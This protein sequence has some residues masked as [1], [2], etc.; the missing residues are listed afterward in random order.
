MPP[1]RCIHRALAAEG[2]RPGSGPGRAG[3]RP[4]SDTGQTRDSHSETRVRRLSQRPQRVE[5]LDVGGAARR[6]VAGD[7]RNKPEKQQHQHIRQRVERA[8]VEQE[9]AQQSAD[10]NRS[11]NPGNDTDRKQSSATRED[12]PDHVFRAS[13]EGHPHTDFP[14]AMRHVVSHHRIQSEG[15]EREGKHRQNSRANCCNP[16]REYPQPQ[17]RLERR[18]AKRTR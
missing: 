13:A 8:D 12:E 9:L 11:A 16:G 3:V 5:R 15:R 1:P 17:Q 14:C 4:G 7:Q 18:G 2:D 10:D 6:H